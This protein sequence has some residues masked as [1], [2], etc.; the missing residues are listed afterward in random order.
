M[1]HI[2]KY[3]NISEQY[4]IRHCHLKYLSML[5][6]PYFEVQTSTS[7]LVLKS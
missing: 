1:K 7:T 4:Y 6:G 5:S 2:W 3:K